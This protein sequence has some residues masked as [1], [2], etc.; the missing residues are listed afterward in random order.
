[1]P[2]PRAPFDG[3]GVQAVDAQLLADLLEHA[4]FDLVVLAIR[5]HHIAGQ[6]IG[7]LVQTLGQGGADQA[8]QGVKAVLLF[9]QIKDDLADAAD[10]V[11]S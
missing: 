6:R 5:R 10:T 9:E 4:Q 8:E 3:G 11:G 2:H 7:G 1:M